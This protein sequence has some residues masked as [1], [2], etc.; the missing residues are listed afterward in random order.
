MT[1]DM[2][3]G[4]G[5][6]GDFTPDIHGLHFEKI[7]ANA[8]NKPLGTIETYERNPVYDFTWKDCTLTHVNVYDKQAIRCENTPQ[9]NITYEQ[10]TVNGKPYQGPGK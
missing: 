5:D 10:V 9:E 8:H 4:G 1:V 7:T 3:Y 6:I 2:A